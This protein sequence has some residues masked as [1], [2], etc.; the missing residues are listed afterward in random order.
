MWNATLFRLRPAWA[1][2][3]CRTRRWAG[4][5]S[6]APWTHRAWEQR[7]P[8]PDPP[9]RRGRR[10]TPTRR[11]WRPSRPWPRNCSANP[12]PG[13]AGLAA[14]AGQATW[15]CPWSPSPARAKRTG[16]TRTW[17]PCRWSSPRRNWSARRGCGRRRR[18][19][20]RGPQ[21]GVPGPRIAGAVS[22]LKPMDTLIHDSTG[23]H[24]PPDFGQR[25]GQQ[26]VS[27]HR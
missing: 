1:S 7:L 9:F 18:L 20:L 25:D 14:R 22:K 19:P 17:A 21:L 3:L 15:A 2:A 6:P 26:R 8:P 16:S 24:H 13:G 27:A 23:H 10:W 4:D 11:W 5:S 12:G